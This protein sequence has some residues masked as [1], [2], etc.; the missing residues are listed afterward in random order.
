EK[1]LETYRQAVLMLAD[2]EGANVDLNKLAETDPAQAQKLFFKRLEFN[3]TLQAITSKQQELLTQRQE[4]M[5]AT[6]QKQA[7]EAVEALERDIP[8]WNQDR[9][10]KVL[11]TG[12][13]YGF[14]AEEVNSITDPRAIKVLDDARNGGSSKQPSLLRRTNRRSLFPR[15]VKP[16]TAEKPDP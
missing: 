9:Y 4:E 13:E 10:S 15:L 2:R 12:M 8:G 6:L 16:G 3:N 5:R 7:K 11:K 14:K 1:Q